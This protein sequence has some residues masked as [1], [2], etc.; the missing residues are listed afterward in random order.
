VADDARAGA[1]TPRRI[2]GGVRQERS[3]IYFAVSAV[4]SFSMRQYL[5]EEGHAL[6]DHLRVV[7]YEELFGLRRLPLGTYVFTDIDWLTP[8]ERQVV[9]HAW[10]RLRDSG[11]DIRLLNHPDRVKLR[12]DLL[13]VA[14]DAGLNRF[15]AFRSSELAFESGARAVARSG[16]TATKSSELRYPVFIRFESRH[17]GT[18]TPLLDTSR[19]LESALA[20]LLAGGL[21][22]S[23][24]LVVEF[25]DTRSDD[26]L[27]RKYS[28][29]Q[30]GDRVFARY[31][32]CSPDWTVK[33]K[34]RIF[35]KER[36]EQEVCYIEANPHEAWIR[37]VFRLACIDYG[38]IDYGVLAGQ[39][40]VWEI[41]TN[42]T[43][44]RPRGPLVPPAP[45][46]AAYKAIVA[47][48]FHLFFRNYLEAWLAL[49]SRAN[50][51]AS[52][53]LTIPPPLR[54]AVALSSRQRRRA[55]R[56]DRWKHSIASRRWIQPFTHALKSALVTLNAARL[57]RP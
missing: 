6:A 51:E 25:C 34:G 11:A 31:L 42:P 20:S 1:A 8:A 45:H 12:Y 26:G 29:F 55:D 46:I 38:R 28:A 30:V 17:Y 57:R 33:W 15:R 4:G 18:L 35:D 56:L 36:A 48:A 39:P 5:Q 23:D 16:T 24:L 41:N 52:V 47:P 40:Q 43:I 27:Y 44:G 2:R 10:D 13:R 50:S 53:E 7:T 14:H 54:R 22:L 49:D 32:D 37:D 21:R 3:V 9:S 19:K